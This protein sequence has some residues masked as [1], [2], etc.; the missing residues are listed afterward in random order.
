LF[1]N[2]P[3]FINFPLRRN[4]RFIHP[5]QNRSYTLS[6]AIFDLDNTLIAGD[7]DHCWGQFLVEQDIVD[8]DSFKEANDRFYED[9]QCGNLDIHAYLAFALEPLTRFSMVELAELHQ[10]FMRE[11]IHPLYLPKAAELIGRHR[12]AGDSLLIITATNSFIT[13]PIADWLGIENLLACDPEVVD[14]RYSGRTVNTPCF[15][16]G[17]VTRLQEWLEEA[18]ETIEDSY[19]YSDSAN[20]IPLLNAVTYPTAVDPCPRLRKH[21]IEQGWPILSLRD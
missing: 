3:S 4:W 9:Y 8:A 17:K 2:L 12:E 14:G 18:G 21:A 6:L 13:R 19:F 15:Q 5:Y 16:H 20:D 10:T 1:H 7:S 11:K